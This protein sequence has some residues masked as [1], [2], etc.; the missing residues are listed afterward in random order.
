MSDLTCHPPLYPVI[1]C[2]VWMFALFLTDVMGVKKKKKNMQFCRIAR[3]SAFHLCIEHYT[4]LLVN[5]TYFHFSEPLFFSEFLLR[6][7]LPDTVNVA[8]LA[9]I[10]FC[11]LVL[12]F[13][14]QALNL[15]ISR[16][17]EELSMD[18]LNTYIRCQVAMN[19]LA[20]FDS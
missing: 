15:A 9:R 17:L 4:F 5:S 13:I 2:G 11:D 14:W 6:S 16:F 19:L 8:N 7:M 10:K 1:C 18:L 20:A 3:L 12:P